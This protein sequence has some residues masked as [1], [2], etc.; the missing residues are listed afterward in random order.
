MRD[1]CYNKTLTM[2]K[3]RVIL[4]CDLN[5]FY[6]SVEC[7]HH[8]ELRNFPL[9]VCGDATLRHGI[10]LAK[11]YKAKAYGVK[12]GDVIW[13]AKS[14]CP[15]LKIVSA[16]LNKYL[17]FSQIVKHIFSGYTDRIESF[18]IDES[19]LDVTGAGGREAADGLR[20]EILLQTGCTASVGV[21][22]NKIFAKLA[23]DMKKPDAT[24]V[25]SKENF[26]EKVWVLPCEDLLYVGK[27]TK[28]KLN[29]YCIKTIGDIA[30]CDVK[31]LKEKLGKW[32]EYLWVF[33]NGQDTSEVAI[34]G[35]ECPI[36]SVGNST[37]A[38]RDLTTEEDIK[39]IV[40][41]LCES[42][43]AR[44]REQWFKGQTVTIYLRDK[45]LQSWGKQIKIDKPTNLS[46]TIIQ[47]AM[48]LFKVYDFSYPVRSVGIKVSD[49]MSAD[50]PLQTDL[51]VSEEL[52]GKAE[53]VEDTV[54]D[55]RRRF[56]HFAINRG[57][58]Y[59]DKELTGFSPKEENVIHPIGYFR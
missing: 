48:A 39:M 12:T 8:P 7:L 23:S 37:T 25:I 21:S 10:V 49:L 31:F 43:A 35:I 41:V 53:K 11:N 44:L 52:R 16:D 51:F 30:V 14:K 24:T 38:I 19:W 3:E 57:I 58:E 45:Y 33:A 50:T 13:E 42:V 22:W 1:I 56:G 59:K 47:A 55:I 5:N 9:V 4:H 54:N 6:A 34:K 15:N 40:T 26:K 2:I 18:G 29:K 17:R 36:K 28:Q 27:A 20:T 32:G 46:A